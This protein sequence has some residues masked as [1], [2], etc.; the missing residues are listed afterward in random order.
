MDYKFLK[1]VLDQILSETRVNDG[2]GE[3]QFPFLITLSDSLHTNP[4]SL[5]LLFSIPHLTSLI[6][7]FSS[8]F[9]KHCEDVYGLNEQEIEYVWRVYRDDIIYK[10]KEEKK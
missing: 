5:S 6:H 2:M 1:K 8:S 10:I 9:S 3:I 4:Y 7:S